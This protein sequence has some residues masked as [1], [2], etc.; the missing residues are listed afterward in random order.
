MGIPEIIWVDMT[1]QENK[2]INDQDKELLLNGWEGRVI[3]YPSKDWGLDKK[4]G[5]KPRKYIPKRIK[6]EGIINS[7]AEY[8]SELM[9]DK[10][11]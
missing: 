8:R 3:P 11:H 6:S 2:R 10:Q 7:A 1:V 9:W 5:G 4:V